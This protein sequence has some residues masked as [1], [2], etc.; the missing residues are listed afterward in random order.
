MQK[1]TATAMMG[2]G[3]RFMVHVD[4]G[5]VGAKSAVKKGKEG[6]GKGLR[7][8]Y[9]MNKA[10]KKEGKDSRVPQQEIGREI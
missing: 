7:K 8:V 1:Y 10:K 6:A 2:F 4:T 9:S 5:L 3:N